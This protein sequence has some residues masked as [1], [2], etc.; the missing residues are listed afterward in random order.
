MQDYGG[1]V[2]FRLACRRPEL[3]RSLIIQNANAYEEGFGPAA[4]N[5]IKMFFTECFDL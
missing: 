2:G 4:D 1:P 3:I 5:R